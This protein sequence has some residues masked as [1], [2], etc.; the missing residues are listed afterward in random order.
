MIH[1]RVQCT[2]TYYYAEPAT[3]YTRFSPY[4][5]FFFQLPFC[6]Q[7]FRA[8]WTAF[9]LYIMPQNHSIMV[10]LVQIK[11]GMCV[12]TSY[13]HSLLMRAN[14]LETATVK[15]WLDWPHHDSFFHARTCTDVDTCTCTYNIVGVLV[16]GD[17]GTCTFEDVVMIFVI[18]CP[19]SNPQ[20]SLKIHSPDRKPLVWVLLT[21]H[22]TTKACYTLHVYNVGPDKPVIAG[23][24]CFELV[25][26]HQQRICIY[27]VHVH[28]QCTYTCNL[29]GIPPCTHVCVH[30][31]LQWYTMYMEDGL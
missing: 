31:P 16:S 29:C 23:Q 1:V 4:N 25:S 2:C 27:N 9:L 14:K 22:I 7:D 20:Y 12:Q 11:L 5:F 30:D 10:H 19:G 28:V 8:P 21:R 24:H 6:I 17:V 3:S 18:S 15:G 13:G 26:S